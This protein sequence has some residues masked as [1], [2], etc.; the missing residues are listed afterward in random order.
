[1]TSS[2]KDPPLVPLGDL[3][4]GLDAHEAE[5]KRLAMLFRMERARAE[6][7][8]AD[9]QAFHFLL[10][11]ELD[12]ADLDRAD[13]VQ[14]ALNRAVRIAIA[15]LE[16]EQGRREEQLEDLARFAGGGAG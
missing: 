5:V 11:R 13:P 1:M 9:I 15:A 12:R 6:E 8:I 7:S 16:R 14:H 10:L 4:A 3:V 2:L